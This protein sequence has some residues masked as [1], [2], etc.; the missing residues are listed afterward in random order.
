MAD[1]LKFT[2]ALLNPLKD[3]PAGLRTCN[4]SDPK[5]RFAVYRNNVSVSLVDALAD[6]FPVTQELVGE[7]FFREMARHYLYRHPPR[8]P[9]LAHYGESFPEFI[10][11]FSPASNLPYLADTARLEIARVQSYHAADALPLPEQTLQA[12][13]SRPD[14]PAATV[15]L[16]PSLRLVT[17]SYAI[18][19]LWSAHHGLIEWSCV[20]TEVAEHA[21]IVRTGLDVAIFP[22]DGGA[23][24]FISAL[25][26]GIDLA[27]SITEASVVSSAFDAA[28]TLALLIRAEALVQLF[29]PNR[30]SS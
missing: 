2:E 28:E 22:I 11:T 25:L 10:A 12:W 14:L 16:H 23:S 27:G 24:A 5:Q 26:E 18:V 3:C 1:L 30:V 21:L 29:V 19:S 13:L 6:T 17:S 15:T 7:D 4:G 8:T 9:V 20:N